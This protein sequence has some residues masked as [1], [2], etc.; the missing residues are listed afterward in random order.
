[1][2][3]ADHA[4]DRL[5]ADYAPLEC[6]GCTA[7][8]ACS[9]ASTAKQSVS[10]SSARGYEHLGIASDPMLKW[11]LGVRFLLPDGFTLSGHLYNVLGTRK[12][13]H[14]VRW[15]HMT[16]ASYGDLYTVDVL[17]FAIAKTL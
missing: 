9:G 15:Q 7:T 5:Y 10:D 2:S 6:C 16:N 11:N 14:A 13:L 17:T 12:N 3:C 1:M 4:R 8:C